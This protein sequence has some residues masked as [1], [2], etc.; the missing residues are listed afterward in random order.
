MATKIVT[1][2]DLDEYPWLVEE[3]D[4]TVGTEVNWEY[5]DAGKGAQTNGDG[6]PL[7]GPKHPPIPP[8]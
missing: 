5:G 4:I 1:Q 8:A 3:W 7:T 6:D 2:E